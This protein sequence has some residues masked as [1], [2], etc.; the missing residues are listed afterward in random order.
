MAAFSIVKLFALNFYLNKKH[1]YALKKDKAQA[2][3]ILLCIIPE[4]FQTIDLHFIFSVSKIILFMISFPHHINVQRPSSIPHVSFDISINI[5][6]SIWKYWTPSWPLE[7]L[8]LFGNIGHN[9]R[10]KFY[11]EIP[12]TIGLHTDRAR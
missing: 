7:I 6:S 2:R 12:D 1:L 5:K 8:V 4:L 9:W 3:C 10:C 11:L